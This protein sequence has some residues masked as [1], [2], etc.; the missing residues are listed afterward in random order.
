MKTVS[1][2]SQD[3][4]SGSCLP[5]KKSAHRPPKLALR[6]QFLHH[7]G[8]VHAGEAIIEA[9][10]TIGELLVIETEERKKRGVKVMHMHR[11]LHGLESEFVGRAMDITTFGA[12]A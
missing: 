11:I 8:F 9:G 2:I 3:W 7:L 6:D 1:Q 10:V 5:I 12:A 4:N